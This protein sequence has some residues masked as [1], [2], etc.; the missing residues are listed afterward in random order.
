MIP[1]QF[2]YTYLKLVEKSAL[3]LD[4]T[5]LSLSHIS[6]HWPILVVSNFFL[7]VAKPVKRNS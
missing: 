3:V 2:I 4:V 1:T 7:I 6:H 5:L